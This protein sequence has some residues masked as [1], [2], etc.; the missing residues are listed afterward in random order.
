MTKLEFFNPS[1]F[2]KCSPSCKIDDMNE[3]FL[4][5][6]DACRRLAGVPFRLN[7]AYRSKS[8]EFFRLRSGKSMHCSGRAV[9]I[10]CTDVISRYKIIAAAS[11]CGLNGIG[12]GKNYIHLDD[13]ETPMIWHYYD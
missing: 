2:P 5:K 13:R 7:S 9:D 4:L 1:E 11:L 10:R 8:Y 12:I 6:L 3:E